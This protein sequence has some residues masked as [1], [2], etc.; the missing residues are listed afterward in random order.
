MRYHEARIEEG[1]RPLRS[2]AARFG[3]IAIVGVVWFGW[4]QMTTVKVPLHY[5][6]GARAA[7]VKELEIVVL[8]V[9]DGAVAKDDF[10]RYSLA[11]S[12]VYKTVRLARGDYDLTARMRLATGEERRTTARITAVSGEHPIEIDLSALV[13][14]PSGS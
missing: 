5:V 2:L 6:L 8:R 14:G 13:T 3:L 12:D 11:P 1:R 7:N 9:K 10:Y 4:Q